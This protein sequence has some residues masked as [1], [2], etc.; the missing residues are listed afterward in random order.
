MNKSAQRANVAVTRIIL[1]LCGVALFF[2]LLEMSMRLGGFVFMFLQEYRNRAVSVAGGAYRIL[3]LGES[4][5]ARQWPGPLEEILNTRAGRG[6]FSVVDKGIIGADTSMILSQLE[7]NLD[8]YDPDIVVIMAGINDRDIRYYQD[9]PEAASWIFCNCRAYRFVRLLYRNMLHTFSKRGWFHDIR[10][11]GD[12]AVHRELGWRYRSDG[13]FPQAEDEFRHI[14]A[15]D[16]DNDNAYCGLGWL[17]N[18]QGK[19]SEGEKYFEKAIAIAPRNGYAFLGLALV[20]KNQGE[21]TKAE[22]AFKT[23]I[24]LEPENANAYIELARFYMSQSRFEEAE[25]FLEKGKA[26]NPQHYHTYIELGWMFARLGRVTE[27]E[28]IFRRAIEVS[29]REDEAY[30]GLGWLYRDQ[31]R[32]SEAHEYFNKAGILQPK[33]G[34]GNRALSILREEREGDGSERHGAA[35][36]EEKNE[37]YPPVT[38]KNMLRISEIVKKRGARLVCV[39]YPMRNLEPLKV[40][41]AGSGHRVSF[42]DNERVFKDAVSAKGYTEYFI[43][44]FAG[45]FGHC[46][47]KGNRLLAGNIADTICTILPGK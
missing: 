31:G 17:S 43:D 37:R 8:I 27:A 36:R 5:T 45:D 30:L 26:I 2:F 25:A 46:T 15:Y 47:D 28:R 10:R 33:D 32:L 44:T 19:F 42:V 35:I 13:R 20:C 4:T 24:R 29:P 22:K 21:L 34:R 12:I 1:T 7:E 40:I 11:F 38:V 3:C 14:L 23:S 6:K 9:I 39:Q 18:D 16:P 41:F